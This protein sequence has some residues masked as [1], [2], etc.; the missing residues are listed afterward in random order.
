MLNM[1]AEELQPDIV[2][3]VKEA[4]AD[5]GFSGRTL[6]TTIFG[7]SLLPRD[8][9]IAVKQL[10]RLVA[11]FGLNDRLVRTSLHRLAQ[12]QLVSSER[13]G[14]V[15]F[16]TVHDSAVTTFGHANLRIYAPPGTTNRWD[17]AWTVA[18]VDSAV[19]TKQDRARLV[20]EL[21]WLG[22]TRQTSLVH[23]SPTVAPA[24][25][26]ALGERLGVG[27]SVVMRSE[28]TSG[29][30][31]DEKQRN[32]Q[33][34]PDGRLRDMH[35]AYQQRFAPVLSVLPTLT[36]EEAFV[37]RTLLIDA[38]RRIALRS[39]SFPLDLV[40]GNWPASDNLTLTKTIHDAVHQTSEGHLD[41]ITGVTGS[42]RSLFA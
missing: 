17:G 31:G 15:S 39:P 11:P 5:P 12:E 42:A 36:S 38:W 9:P 23:V 28:L 37:V 21:G 8:Q 3:L 16:Y 1:K 41:E 13:R 6:L 30:V 40:P 29:S 24:T 10:V 26:V 22:M 32:R 2:G 14:R 7:D 4:V 33:M 35:E 18:V 19:G 34:D 25:L 20:A 27:Y